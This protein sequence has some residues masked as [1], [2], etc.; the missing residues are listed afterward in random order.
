MFDE[1]AH[2]NVAN[3]CLLDYRGSLSGIEG[4][5][6]IPHDDRTDSATHPDPFLAATTAEAWSWLVPN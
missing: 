1:T 3:G 4:D 6:I 2:T 5:V